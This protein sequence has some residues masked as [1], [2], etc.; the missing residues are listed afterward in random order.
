MH[1][2]PT[3]VLLLLAALGALAWLPACGDDDA[4]TDGGADGD[5]DTDSDTDADADAGPDGGATADNSFA[6]WDGVTL[7]EGGSSTFLAGVNG[8]F[9]IASHT[10]QNDADAPTYVVSVE[11]W[12]GT[13]AG[14]SEPGTYEIT[15]TE[16]N[17]V[18]C[19]LCIIA[20][21][22]GADGSAT[23]MY[24]PKAGSG[25]VTIDSIALGAAG[26]GTVFA[27]S[28]DLELQAVTD[29]QT[30]AVDATGC[31]G[32]INY[33]WSG[34]AAEIIDGI[35][36]DVG[37]PIDNA[38]FTGYADADMSGLIDTDEQTDVEFGFD[39]IF[40]DTGKKTL[41]VVMGQES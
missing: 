9:D 12:G 25:S 14:P 19:G 24:M 29:T 16:T 7:G 15:A 20:Y 30:G 28:M 38:T 4:A 5:T 32:P 40:A 21:E 31:A 17:Y 3:L 39:S 37:E 11:S 1:R 26:V 41:I 10:W 23:A 8:G 34:T 2:N 18:D 27:G 22:V 36:A 33:S 35:P 13:Y 6:C